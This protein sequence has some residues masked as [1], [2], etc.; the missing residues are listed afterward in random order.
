MESTG[1]YWSRERVGI[2]KK[3]LVGNLKSSLYLFYHNTIS[4]TK[5]SGDKTDKFYEWVL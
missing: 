3:Q 2:T 5:N 1:W 4:L